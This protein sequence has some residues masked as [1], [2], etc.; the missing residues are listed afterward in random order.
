MPDLETHQLNDDGDIPNNSRLPLIVYRGALD[1]ESDDGERRFKELFK[2]NGW[3]GSWVDSIYPF[4]HYHSTAH[5]VLGIA[6]GS[7]RVQFGGR[8]GPTVEVQA[9]DAVFIPAGVGHCRVSREAGLSVVGAYPEGQ[10]WDLRREG[11]TDKEAIRRAIDHLP[12]P[13]RDPVMGTPF[14]SR[15]SARP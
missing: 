9:G 6:R 4:H 15:P 1:A 10:D 8:G 11:E 14:L 2:A 5:E 3:G 13:E 7:V 12:L